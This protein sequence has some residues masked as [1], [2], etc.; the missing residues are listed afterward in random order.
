MKKFAQR[1][2]RFAEVIGPAEVASLAPTFP[3]LETDE[4]V[5]ILLPASPTHERNQP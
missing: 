4:L 2:H 5:R 3:S 1:F